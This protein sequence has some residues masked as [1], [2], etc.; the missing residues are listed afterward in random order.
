[1]FVCNGIAQ[2]IQLMDLRNNKHYFE[3]NRKVILSVCVFVGNLTV[4]FIQIF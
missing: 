3:G 1:M 2:I 4:N